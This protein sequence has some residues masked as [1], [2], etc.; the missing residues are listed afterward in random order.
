[1]IEL[2]Y[3]GRNLSFSEE[4]ILNPGLHYNTLCHIPSDINEHL[5]VL[6]KYAEECQ[7]VTEI[8][9]RYACST[10]AF[11]EARPKKIR[12]YDIDYKPFQPSEKY[13]EIVSENYGIDFSFILGD[14]LSFKIENTDLLF[15]DTLHT[16]NQLYAELS[17]HSQNVNK[18]IILH[19]TVTFGYRDEYIYEHASILVKE[20]KPNKTG[21]IAAIE[22][23]LKDNKEWYIHEVYNNNNGLTILKRI[24][25]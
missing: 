12:C 23:F 5:P 4:D 3:G 1:M 11:L 6:K 18:Y 24:R 25:N 9:V 22:D 16:Y 2:N 8:G 21:L 20:M 19:D 17:I 13:I 14:S 7:Y 10:W 15:I